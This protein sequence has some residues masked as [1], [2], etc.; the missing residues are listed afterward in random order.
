MKIKIVNGFDGLE[1]RLV[2]IQKIEKNEIILKLTGKILNQPTK[3]TIQ[4][5]HKKHLKNSF[6]DYLNH[7]CNPNSHV[8]TEKLSIVADRPIKP[9]DDITVNYLSTEYIMANPFKC[10]CRS[11]ICFK[12]IRGY[13]FL[14]KNK[15]VT[16]IANH[17]LKPENK[18]N[19]D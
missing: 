15:R 10:N 18:L 16:N 8:D 11:K 17:L 5:D 13:N 4:I 19:V 7:S 14:N 2:A 6:V 3:Q 1:K 12:E 9:F